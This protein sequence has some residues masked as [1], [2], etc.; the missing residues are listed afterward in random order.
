MFCS[1]ICLPTAFR[2]AHEV[3]QSIEWHGLVS[4]VERK[5]TALSCHR[6]VLSNPRPQDNMRRGTAEE[7]TQHNRRDNKHTGYAELKKRKN[8]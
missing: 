8:K 3:E 4:Q 2:H 1:P 7:K 5:I 6:P